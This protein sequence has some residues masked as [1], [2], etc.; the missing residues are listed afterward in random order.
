MST[1]FFNI[2][3]NI[4]FAVSLCFKI[5]ARDMHRIRHVL[6]TQKHRSVHLI[7]ILIPRETNFIRHIHWLFH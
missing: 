2:I 6:V 7:H 3:P 1:L 4:R 5:A